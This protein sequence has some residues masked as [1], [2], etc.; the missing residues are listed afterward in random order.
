MRRHAS[1]AALAA[2]MVL[3]RSGH[4]GTAWSP[5][6]ASWAVLY[7]GGFYLARQWRWALPGLFFTAVAVDFIVIR[8]F[9]VSA[10]CV[11][12]AYVFM[13]PAYSI[14]WLG[15]VWLRR[16]YRH[17]LADLARSAVSLGLAA[18][19]CFLITNAS[20]YWLGGRVPDPSLGGWW[21]NLAQWYPGFVGV[22]FIYVGIA[23]LL[24]AALARPSR[25]PVE[26]D[27]H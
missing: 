17:E 16:T 24:H 26:A 7:I 8:E 2:L 1:F 27:A 11:T 9:G 19:L 22:P 13:L 21:Q 6:D 15:G 10:Y 5:P 25:A 18:S 3:T 12:V 20:F 14:L 4:L 23:A